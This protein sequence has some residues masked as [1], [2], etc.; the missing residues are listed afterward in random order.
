M[1]F[2]PLLHTLAQRRGFRTYLTGLLMPRDRSKTLTVLVGAEPLVQAQAAEVQQL[3]FF[4]SEAAWNAE[5][6]TERRLLLL[7][8]APVSAPSAT[9]VLMIDDTGDRKHGHS[10][11][12]VSRQY[13]GSIGKTDNGIVAVTSLWADEQHYYPLHVEP[14]TPM[15]HELACWART[16]QRYWSEY[17]SDGQTRH[18]MMFSPAKVD[19][20]G[21]RALRP[22][23]MPRKRQGN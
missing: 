10:T 9:G 6:I 12:H 5:A 22:L 3:Q 2:D 8:Q 13:L 4:L 7:A 16:E 14:Y 21:Q 11:D 23:G 17:S 19:Q 18:C 1:Q 15:P 20:R